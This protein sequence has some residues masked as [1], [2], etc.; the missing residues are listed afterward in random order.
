[1]A[2]SSSKR[3]RDRGRSFCRMGEPSGGLFCQ[4]QVRRSTRNPHRPH[5]DS[6]FGTPCARI[7]EQPGQCPIVPIS[8][9]DPFAGRRQPAQFMFALDGRRLFRQFW[10][11]HPGHWGFLHLTLLFTPF[12]EL[13][14]APVPVFSSIGFPPCQ[15]IC[16]KRLRVFAT[17]AGDRL[18][19]TLGD[20][21][22]LKEAQCLQRS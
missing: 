16:D 21:E 6:Q 10:W 22:P 12:E 5:L 11:L 18:R 1:M 8:K 3:A 13:L 19:H 20:K 17:D 15:Q 2:T 9:G 7:Q 4:Q 14:Q